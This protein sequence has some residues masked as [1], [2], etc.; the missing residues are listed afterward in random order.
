MEKKGFEARMKSAEVME[1][2]SGN[3]ETGTLT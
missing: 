2:E 1:G 3:A